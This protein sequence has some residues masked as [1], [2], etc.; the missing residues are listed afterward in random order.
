MNDG[1]TPAR[2]RASNADR[3]RVVEALRAAAAD[4]R[5]D[6]AEFEE[7]VDRVYRARTLGELPAALADLL[8]P[9]RQPLQLDERP[10]VAMFTT[11]R[12]AG[13]WVVRPTEP[14]AA[15]GG[16]L[17]LDLREALLVRGHVRMPVLCV[18][19]RVLITVP[20]GVEVRMRGRS[21]LGRRTTA[22]RPPRRADAPVLEV[23]GFS[24]LGTVRV[25]P[26]RRARGRLP[27]RRRRAA[28]E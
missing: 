28:L 5:L 13:R 10:L 15:V 25:R 4:G 11:L 20:E 12:R 8:P 14:A 16:T 6:L 21:L 23:S 9:D 17:E 19:G 3:E 18:F 24:L 1:P 7:R 22:V 27:W 2:L 26:P